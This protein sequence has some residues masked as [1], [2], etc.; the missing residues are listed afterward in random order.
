MS[1]QH[2]S[3]WDISCWPKLCRNI[4][5]CPTGNIPTAFFCVGIFPVGQFC[6]DISFWHNVGIFPI[7]CVGTSTFPR[8]WVYNVHGRY[9]IYFVNGFLSKVPANFPIEGSVFEFNHKKLDFGRQMAVLVKSTP[10]KVLNFAPK[11]S[12]SINIPTKYIY[13]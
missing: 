12:C 3:C 5:C 11:L 2:I 1:R 10:P 13:F 8:T 7:G 6:R 9:N 4:S